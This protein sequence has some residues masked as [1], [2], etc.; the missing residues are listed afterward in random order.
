MTFVVHQNCG[1]LP[2]HAQYLSRDSIPAIRQEQSG[3]PARCGRQGPL[4]HLGQYP[5][6]LIAFVAADDQAALGGS[7]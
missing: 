4:D 6:L 5:E 7:E 1:S 2:N 3:P